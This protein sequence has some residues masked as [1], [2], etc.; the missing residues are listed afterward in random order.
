MAIR[1]LSIVTLDTVLDCGPRLA[2]DDALPPLVDV[3]AGLDEVS[4]ASLEEAV[5]EGDV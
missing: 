4:G 3:R 1:L 5:A 2:V